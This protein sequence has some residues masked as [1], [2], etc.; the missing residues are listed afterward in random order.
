MTITSPSKSCA[1]AI[2]SSM[3]W[4]TNTPS[5]DHAVSRVTTML[6]RKGSGCPIDSKV[7]RPI[8]TVL[9]R[10]TA[11]KCLRSSG[12]LHGMSPSWPIT[13]FSATAATWTIFFLL[14]RGPRGGAS[15]ASAVVGWSYRDRGLDAGVRVV[16][17]DRD[18][19]EVERVELGDRGVQPQG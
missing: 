16:A 6:L 9:S 8:T 3:S 7:R 19:L 13:P 5:W 11:R 4:A 12:M 2:A 1:S 14:I 17:L 15:A 18:V 10:V